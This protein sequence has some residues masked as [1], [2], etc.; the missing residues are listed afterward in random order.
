MP[1]ARRG[2]LEARWATRLQLFGFTSYLDLRNSGL[3]PSL[4]I[5]LWKSHATAADLYSDH[6]LLAYEAHEQGWIKRSRDYVATDAFFG[7]LQRHGIRFYGAAVA[8]ASI[9]GDY[10]DLVEAERGVLA[11]PAPA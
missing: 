9:L 4:D 7:V 5:S 8:P 3:L 11:L 1:E 10:G 2:Q 6:W